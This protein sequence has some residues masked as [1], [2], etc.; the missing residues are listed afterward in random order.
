ML[1][2]GIIDACSHIPTKHINT[3]CAQNAE[4]LEKTGGIYSDHWDVKG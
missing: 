1:Y 4:L 2:R 3:L